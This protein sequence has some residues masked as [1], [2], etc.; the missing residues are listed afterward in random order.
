MN[1]LPDESSIQHVSD[2]ALWVAV[3]RAQESERPDALFRDPL[4]AKLAGERGFAIAKGMM[5]GRYTGWALVI[6]TVIIDNF[7]LDLVAQGVDTVVNLGAGLD[8]RPYRMNL[9]FDLRWIEVDFPHM[10]QFKERQLRDEKPKC[11]LERVALDLSDRPTRQNLFGQIARSSKRT[12]IL[13]EGVI[14]YLEARQ[15]GELADD[16]KAQ[17]FSYWITDYFSPMVMQRMMRGRRRRQMKNAPFKFAPGDWF[18]F[19]AKHGWQRRELRYL[20]EESQRLGRPVPM[21]WWASVLVFLSRGRLNH[22][23]LRFIGYVLL[24]PG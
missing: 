18:G 13:T 21:P 15:V 19:F 14:P 8:T 2:T 7:I 12:L 9:P 3:Y 11:K 22:E 24:T 4:A 16:L 5:D 23:S 1:S 6:R 20:G 17:Q 10:I